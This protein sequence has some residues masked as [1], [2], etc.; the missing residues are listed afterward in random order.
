MKAYL[1]QLE[2][3]NSTCQ[4]LQ[5]FTMYLRSQPTDTT[6]AE[7]AVERDIDI[8]NDKA[9]AIM[10]L[11]HAASEI[12]PLAVQTGG[13]LVPVHISERELLRN[14]TPEA[15]ADLVTAKM[16]VALS[17]IMNTIGARGEQL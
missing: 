4:A 2:S 12:V 17:T 15:I 6:V 5:A 9:R 16:Q 10:K 3:M 1:E 14:P 13:I 8:L 7:L 11:M